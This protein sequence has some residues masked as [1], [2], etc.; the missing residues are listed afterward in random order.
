MREKQIYARPPEYPE[1]WGDDGQFSQNQNWGNQANA[2]YNNS[3]YNDEG[4]PNPNAQVFDEAFEVPKQKFNDIPFAALFLATVVGF[5]VVSVISIKAYKSTFNFQ[6]TSIYNSGNTFSV[7]THTVILFGFAIVIA[8]VLS[9]A[10]LML[11][12]FHAKSFIKF[13]MIFNFI[14]GLGT[15]IYYLAMRYW[16]AGIPALVFTIITGISYWTMRKRIPFSATVLEIVIDVM[17]GRPSTLVV[18]ILGAV[19]TAAFSCLFTISVVATYAKYDTNSNNPNCT[20][21]GCSSG[22]LVGLIIFLFFAGYYITEVMRNVIHV[23]IS[24]VYGTW[25]YLSKSDQGEPKLAAWGAFKRAVTYSFGSICLGSLIVTIIQMLRQFCQFLSSPQNAMIGGQ[26]GIGAA[27]MVVM[28]I[29]V[30]FVEWAARFF[31]QYAFSYIA[32]YGESYVQS[33]KNTWKLIKHNGMSALVNDCLIGSALL[34]YCLFVGYAA[35][36][37]SYLFLRLTQPEYNST[38][39]FYA[40]IVAFTF[41]IAMQITHV[42][43]TVVKSGTSTF[44]TALSRDPEV[45][46]A[47]Y[48]QSYNEIFQNYPDVVKKLNPVGV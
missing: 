28:E 40:P 45:L 43:T 37:F 36:L 26:D 16:S 9:V 10:I 23:T 39:G 5:I 34:F 17:K 47:C 46:Q 18:S 27:V 20:S 25:Y 44:F 11:A 48:P 33:A 35:A 22:K 14:F 38:G 30:G 8:L 15:A 3:R 13:S 29:L 41:V 32:L 24:G 12:R 21:G 6:G 1:T 7:N 4:K 19:V 31:N 42:A 2:N